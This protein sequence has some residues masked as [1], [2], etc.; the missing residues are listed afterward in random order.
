LTKL[1]SKEDGM[2]FGTQCIIIITKFALSTR[3]HLMLDYLAV[4]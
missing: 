4:A 1:S 2:F 3:R